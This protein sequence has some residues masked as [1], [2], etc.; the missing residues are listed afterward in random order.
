M[1]FF[2]IFPQFRQEPDTALQN[3][4]LRLIAAAALP[5]DNDAFYFELRDERYWVKGP[6]GNVRIGMGGA[7]VGA[8]AHD[9]LRALVRYLRDA[10]NVSARAI[11]AS[12]VLLLEGDRCVALSGSWLEFP[13]APHWLIL[14]PPQ[15]GGSEMPDALAQV[16]YLLPL[17]QSP[18]PV[19]VTGIVRVKREALPVFLDAASWSLSV[20]QTSPWA[21]LRL[22]KALPADAELQPVLSLR[23]MQRVW[24]EGLLEASLH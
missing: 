3:R 20:L 1:D 8:D 17:R 19:S 14:T 2:E 21:E 10:W 5:H 15:L 13:T 18:Y 12:R 24:R 23:A 9:P 11:T 6:Q 7:Q 22:R 4:A 16:V